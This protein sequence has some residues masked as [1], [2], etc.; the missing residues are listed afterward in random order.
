MQGS[1]NNSNLT[2]TANP[3]G[4][5]FNRAD[6]LRQRSTS[7]RRSSSLSRVSSDR[8][9]GSICLSHELADQILADVESSAVAW[10]GDSGDRVVCEEEEMDNNF[11]IDPVSHD[12]WGFCGAW[13]IATDGYKISTGWGTD[14]FHFNRGK[15]IAYLKRCTICKQVQWTILNLVYSCTYF[16]VVSNFNSSGE[17]IQAAS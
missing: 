14:S 1:S 15:F 13:R 9:L 7:S 17:T 11:T 12:S 10:I 2:N 8:V 4:F 3:Q 5:S 6:S 16:D